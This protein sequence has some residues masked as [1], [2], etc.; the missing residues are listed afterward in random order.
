VR[1]ILEAVRKKVI[2]DIATAPDGS[3]TSYRQSQILGEI[4]RL[5]NEA[6]STIK[7]DLAAGIGNSWDEGVSMLP[8]MARGAGVTLTTF[9]ISNHLTE[10]IRD[11]TWGKISGLTNDA[12][13]K[14]RAEITMGILGQK[15]PQE[16]ASAIAG[17]LERPGIFASIAAR[18]EVIVKTEMGRAFS[19][20]HQ[21]GLES[22]LDTLPGLQKMWLHAGHPKTPRIPHLNLNGNTTPVDTPFLV[23]S[24][25]MMY[26]RDPKA[27]VGEIINCGCMH[28]AWMAAWG[29]KKEFVKSWNEAQKAANKP[30]RT[31]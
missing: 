4:D 25:A 31:P 28:V 26:P 5:L 29:T 30:K 11:F 12:Q 3:F 8:S 6:G 23:G 24:I 21:A 1:R 13:A 17:T 16:I 10:Q 2:A 22:A 15:T 19:M 20:A 7:T 14:I 9:G 18:A 27:P